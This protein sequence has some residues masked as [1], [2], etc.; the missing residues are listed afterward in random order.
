MQRDRLRPGPGRPPKP[1]NQ[2]RIVVPISVAPTFD[3]WL[4]EQKEQLGLSKGEVIERIINAMRETQPRYVEEL[5]SKP[6][7]E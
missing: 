2:K 4:R 1:Q 5:L 6:K 3:A 7:D